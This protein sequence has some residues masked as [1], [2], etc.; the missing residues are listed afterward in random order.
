MPNERRQ[1]DSRDVGMPVPATEWLM[2]GWGG[3][4][5]G[6]ES[7]GTESRAISCVSTKT[8][9]NADTDYCNP[10][11]K[12]VGDQA[13]YNATPC[14]PPPPP[15]PVVP[16]VPV[17]PVTPWTPPAVIPAT[18]VTPAPVPAPVTPW[19][20]PAVTPPAPAPAAPVATPVAAPAPVA[21]PIERTIG[22]DWSV[23]GGRSVIVKE[24]ANTGRTPCVTTLGRM[25]GG[26]NTQCD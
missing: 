4:S 18:P 6:C 19:T 21:A 16:V 1:Y 14:P 20:P 15:P 17:V 5:A 12:P 9:A 13:C 8:G 22:N 24:S 23:V 2:G 10:A 11:T 25:G 3:C 26:M 7:W